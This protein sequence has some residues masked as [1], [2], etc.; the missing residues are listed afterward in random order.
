MNLREQDTIQSMLLL[1]SHLVIWLLAT[2]WTVTRQAPLFSAIFQNL[3][4][5]MSIEWKCFLTIS[6]SAAP[7]FFC[8]QS[9]SASGSFPM[10]RLFTSSDQ[11]TSFSFSISPSNEYSGL[12]S[13]RIDWFDLLAVQETLKSLLQHHNLKASILQHSAFFMVQLSHSYMTTWKII[14]LTMWTFGSKVMSLFFNTL[15][16]FDTAF[17]SRSVFYFHGCSHCLKWFWSPRK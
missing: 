8:L 9:F 13:F 3:L 5:L 15:S 6:S 4:K 16:R 1:F 11:S 17:L 7:S 2:P 14:A 12:T 10:S